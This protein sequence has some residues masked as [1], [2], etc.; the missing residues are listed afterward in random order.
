[1]GI[2]LLNVQ[3]KDHHHYIGDIDIYDND[4]DDHDLDINY[5]DVYDD[6]ND[7]I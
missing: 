4:R 6:T 1:L 3:K 2:E 5:G 7:N